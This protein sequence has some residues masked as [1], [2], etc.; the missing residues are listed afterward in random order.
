MTHPVGV[1]KPPASPSKP[2]EKAVRPFLKWAGG[3]R[4]L[5][6]HIRQFYPETFSEYHEPFAGSGAVFFDLYNR[7]LLA[8]RQV[9]L[10]DNNADLI[11]CYLTVRNQ[12]AAVIR[13]LTRLA[14]EYRRSPKE[15]YYRVRDTQ[16][17]PQR[18]RIFNGNSPESLRYTPALAAKLIYMNRT[19]F[20]GLFRLNSKGLFNVPLGRYANP[21]I[22]DR[23]NLTLVSQALTDTRADITR[24]GFEAVLDRAQ[25]GD[26]LYLD[27][28]YAPRAAR[29]SS[30]RTP[31]PVSR[32]LTSSAFRRS[33]WSWQRGA[34]GSC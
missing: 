22:C 12:V 24:A 28:P 3:K 8:D 26:F 33:L 16:F 9:S 32:W 30:R 10:I 23:D 17:N 20:N 2:T 1:E 14:A 29:P 25:A 31:L 27:P 11:G 34:A 5:L 7:G 18:R 13:H 15:H 4:Q 19:G 6:P 21:L